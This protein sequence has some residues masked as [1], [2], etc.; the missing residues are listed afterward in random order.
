MMVLVK[1][2]E[3]GE[4][5]PELTKAVEEALAKGKWTVAGYNEKFG[6]TF[7]TPDRTISSS[8][9]ACFFHQFKGNLSAI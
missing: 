7:L 8:N 1:I 9:Q 3:L 2:S 6:K 4:A 5:K